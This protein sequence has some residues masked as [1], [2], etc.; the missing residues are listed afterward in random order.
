MSKIIVILI[1]L[2]FFKTDASA[3]VQTS[4]KG[5][6]GAYYPNAAAETPDKLRQI[7]ASWFYSWHA[8]LHGFNIESRSC[9][10]FVPMIRY[11]D[12][13]ADAFQKIEQV[14]SSGKRGL[15]WL[16]GNEPDMSATSDSDGYRRDPTAI[17]NGYAAYAQKIKT[18]DP[19]AKIIVGGFVTPSNITASSQTPQPPAYNMA[20]LLKDNLKGKN[21]TPEGW[22]IH[23]YNCCQLEDF[24]TALRYWKD[25]Q[26]RVL[27]GGETWITE[28]G[29]LQ[30]RAGMLDFMQNTVNFMES[31]QEA[32]YLV[33]R[34][35]WFSIKESQI[36]GGLFDENGNITSFGQTYAN[37]P[38]N[39]PS[40][41]P[42]LAISPP[43]TPTRTPTPTPL[44]TNTPF[45][46]PTFFSTPTLNPTTPPIVDLSPGWN[47]VNP[48]E[49]PDPSLTSRCVSATKKISQ[50]WK[51]TFATTPNTKHY[52]RCY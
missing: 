26:N 31:N 20:R 27:G 33:N 16:I 22:H 24:K 38:P 49:S 17:L 50:F 12:N 25:W 40:P 46:T 10:P 35:S 37:L 23:L 43:P 52:F 45:P 3:S 48:R 18:L 47:F 44:T 36:P 15:Y 1:L 2:L 5:V 39:G 4:K 8:E 19:T 41:A 30:N 9:T 14:I 7:G 29:S 11:F 51:I 28:F 42:C 34:Y 32:Q 13:Q 21:I 6:A